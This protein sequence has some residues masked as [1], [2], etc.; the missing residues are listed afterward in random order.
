LKNLQT[1]DKENIEEDRIKK[2]QEF[3]KNPR[4]ELNHLQTISM[5]AANLAS[6]VIAMDKFYNVNLIIKPKKAKLAESNAI[7]E[8]IAGKLRVKQA[9]L[10]VVQ[11]KV[12]ALKAD[13][14]ATRDYKQKLERDVADCEAKLDRATKLIGG[15]GGEKAR[16]NE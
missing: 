4:F 13:L 1:Y 14:K 6:W 5:V 8:E 2:L 9:E 10:K 15:L 3:L 16:W 7:Y 11:D 12:D